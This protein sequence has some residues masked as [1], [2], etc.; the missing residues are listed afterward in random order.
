MAR[1][2]DKLSALRV[3]KE[4]NPGL[5]SD[6]VGLYLRVTKSGAKSWVFRYMLDRHSHEMGLRAIH[7]VSLA[8]ARQK[9]ASARSLCARGV[10]PLVAKNAA[11]HSAT[12]PWRA[13]LCCEFGVRKRVEFAAF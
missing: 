2:V 1:T 3:A 12:I 8:D 9:A 5:Y 7:A 10:D 4:T 13:A 6:G 11:D